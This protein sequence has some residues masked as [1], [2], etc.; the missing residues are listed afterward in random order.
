[1]AE[2]QAL[3]KIDFDHQPRE[4]FKNR[5]SQFRDNPPT[6]IQPDFTFETAGFPNF[7]VN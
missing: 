1:M 3:K 6:A 4:R 5:I 7:Y 2:I